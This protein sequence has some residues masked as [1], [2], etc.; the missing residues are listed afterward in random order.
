MAAY[1]RAV[2]GHPWRMPYQVYEQTYAANPMF[3]WQSDWSVPEYRHRVLA[4]FHAGWSRDFCYEHLTPAGFLRRNGDKVLRLALF[5]LGVGLVIPLLALRPATARPWVRLAGVGCL[6]QLLGLTLT[7]YGGCNPHYVAPAAG[8]LAV[9]IVA[10]LRQ[11]YVW[12]WHGRRLGQAVVY[13]IGLSYPFL[14]VLS[15]LAEPAIPAEATHVAR[16]ALLR[17]LEHDPRRHLVVVRYHHPRPHGL[18]HEDW[19]FNEA[20]ID[21]ARVVWARAINPEADRR[22]L[23]Y[24]GD[25]QA[26]LLEVQVDQGTYRL[27][28]HPLQS[29]GKLSSSPGASGPGDRPVGGS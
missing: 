23:D 7:Y 19:V 6:V 29:G 1:N 16:A 8:L 3:L 24:F 4:L 11:L 13:A 12:R 27:S 15:A 21:A 28:P 20:D 25:R 14:L 10:G 26:W 2:T 9:L 18:G 17:Q 22:L 5:Y